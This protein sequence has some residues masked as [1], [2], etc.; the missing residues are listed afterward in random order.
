MYVAVKAAVSSGGTLQCSG[1]AKVVL[2]LP[3]SHCFVILFLLRTAGKIKDH[4]AFLLLFVFFPSPTI[5]S[6]TQFNLCSILLT[7]WPYFGRT[8]GLFLFLQSSCV[9]K[10]W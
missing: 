4:A 10:S 9:Q 1:P 5:L 6:F 7:L 2:S 8:Q 3:H